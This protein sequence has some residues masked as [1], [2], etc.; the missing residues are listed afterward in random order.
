MSVVIGLETQAGE[1]Q[2]RC[3]ERTEQL[4]VAR[5]EYALN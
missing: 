2:S 5:K 1:K 4:L 3:Q